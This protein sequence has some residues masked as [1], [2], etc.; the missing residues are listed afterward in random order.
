M[1]PSSMTFEHISRRNQET[2]C[3]PR[4]KLSRDIYVCGSGCVWDNTGVPCFL[5]RE[6]LGLA[7]V[8]ALWM[9]SNVAADAGYGT[10]TRVYLRTV[11]SSSCDRRHLRAS[12]ATTQTPFVEFR[13]TFSSSCLHCQT[14]KCR[15]TTYQQSISKYGPSAA[16]V[17]TALLLRTRLQQL[18]V[19]YIFGPSY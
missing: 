17:Y 14:A 11:S 4:E 1:A 13:A 15:V 5:P 3:F 9:V 8:C 7:E 10:R 16:E 18:K 6:G 2:I 19:N 12:S